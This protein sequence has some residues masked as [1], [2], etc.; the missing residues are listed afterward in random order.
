MSYEVTIKTEKPLDLLTFLALQDFDVESLGDNVYRVVR[1]DELPVFM[2]VDDVRIYF[3]VDLGPVAAVDSKD[4]FNRLLDLNTEI[5]PVAI[6]I[7]SANPEDERLVL[8]ESRV[9]VDLCDAEVLAV[10]DALELA[11]DR[12][13]PVLAEALT[14]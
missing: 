1:G 3:E 4:F 9:T 6:G 5:L 14:A 7:N 12:L 11:V 10:F 13:E 2:R 8:V